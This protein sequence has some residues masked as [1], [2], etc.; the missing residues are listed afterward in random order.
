MGLSRWPNAV[1]TA[2]RHAVTDLDVVEICA[3]TGGQALGLDT[4]V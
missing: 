3:G 4:P 1:R 2:R